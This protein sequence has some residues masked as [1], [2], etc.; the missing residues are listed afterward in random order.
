LLKKGYSKKR[1]RIISSFI[2]TYVN[3]SKP[4]YNRKFDESTTILSKNTNNMGIIET[5]EHINKELEAKGRKEG[6]TEAKIIAEK[7]QLI[8]QLQR[9]HKAL[10]KKITINTIAAIEDIPVLFVK[11]FKKQITEKSLPLLIQQITK[12]YQQVKVDT[13]KKIQQQWLMQLWIKQRFSDVAI[14]G[15]LKVP[16][17]LVALV[18]KEINQNNN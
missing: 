8:Q 6:K 2:K 10:Q 17:K 18:R 4:E 9:I 15:F 12:L 5:I 1:I 14:A 13:S 11:D 3:F 7:Q 16:I